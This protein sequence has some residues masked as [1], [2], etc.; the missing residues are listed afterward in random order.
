MAIFSLNHSYIGR[1]KHAPGA[2]SG[3][4]R[5]V[6]R[7]GACTD[8]IG[9]RLPTDPKDLA[10]WLDEQEQ[11]D[12][13]NARV[14][15]KLIVA[16]PIELSHEANLQ[17]LSEFCERMTEGRASWYAAV[18]DGPDD[19]DNPHAHIIFR[20]RDPDTGQ[21]VMM[22]TEKGSTERF[23]QGWE[24]EVN[25]ALERAG[26]DVRVD[27]RSL[28]EQGIDREA[29]LHVGAGAMALAKKEYEFESNQKEIT[30]LVWGEQNTVTVNYPAI[31]QG[32]TRFDENEERKARNS[33]R[34]L[35]S[36]WHDLK[37]THH[38]HMVS[39]QWSANKWA[40]KAH[41]R[42]NQGSPRITEEGHEES[43]PSDRVV[44]REEMTDNVVERVN[45]QARQEMT[46]SKVEVWESRMSDM[47]RAMREAM[48]QQRER[49]REQG[50]AMER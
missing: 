16:L 10:A 34:E 47:A 32:K 11:G 1:S 5:Y 39:Q 27:R 45:K 17:L 36:N 33:E 42:A 19:A 23:R 25:I 50:M 13:K 14:I 18:H 28:E 46:D 2:A 20:D 40:E 29:Q 21:R 3:S 4:V 44:I 37:W 26:L 9:K 12:R 7:P 22:T 43:D 31:D 30:R 48:E 8:S 6:T 35:D 15:D 24:Q 41:A 38:G 49:D